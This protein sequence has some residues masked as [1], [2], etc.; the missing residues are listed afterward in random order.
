M[1][2]LTAIESDSKDA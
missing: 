2:A 1:E